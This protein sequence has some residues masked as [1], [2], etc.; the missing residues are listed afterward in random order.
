MEDALLHSG[1]YFLFNIF[2]FCKTYI[3]E[4]FKVLYPYNLNM[5][6]RKYLHLFIFFSCFSISGFSQENG[7]END[8]IKLYQKIEEFSQKTKLTKMLHNLVFK[9]TS[10]SER[11]GIRIRERSEER[12]V[13]KEW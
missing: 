13:G 6:L 10:K 8:S 5:K 1:L 3:F 4:Q 2:Y 7:T 12:R 11:S 9:P